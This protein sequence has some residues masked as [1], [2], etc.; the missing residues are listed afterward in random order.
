M[1][2]LQVSGY[3][4]QTERLAVF[5]PVPDDLADAVREL[6][7]VGPLD[8]G[9]G[10]YPLDAATVLALGRRMGGDLDPNLYDWMLEPALTD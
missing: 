6:A 8:D 10:A 5:H 7:R 3:D 4:K 1:S 9:E 2:L